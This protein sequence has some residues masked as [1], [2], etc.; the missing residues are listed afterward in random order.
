MKKSVFIVTALAMALTACSAGR[1]GDKG[2]SPVLV[3][4]P[5]GSRPNLF[6]K[7]DAYIIVDQDPIY[8]AADP[9]S[10]TWAL[11][12]NSSYYFANNNAVSIPNPPRPNRFQ[13]QT[14]GTPAKLI[15]CTYDKEHK[16]KYIYSITVTDGI[17]TVT[18]DPSIVNP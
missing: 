4:P 3:T 18:S 10:I 7:D 14:I 11:A 13:C 1:I 15:T 17:H 9:A 2:F 8:V 16:K 6:I 5:D 12:D